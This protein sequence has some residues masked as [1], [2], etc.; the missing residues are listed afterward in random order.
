MKGEEEK[1]RRKIKQKREREGRKGKKKRARRG[2]KGR[3]R[4]IYME[5]GKKS[6][7]KNVKPYTT[8]EQ[9]Q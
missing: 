8:N 6:G 1:V 2:K 3:E 7:W 5:G 4:E 9:K